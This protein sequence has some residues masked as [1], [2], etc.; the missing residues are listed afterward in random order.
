MDALI[1]VIFGTFMLLAFEMGKRVEKTDKPIVE[2]KVKKEK[3]ER[4]K[5]Q[6]FVDLDEASTIMLENL[7]NYDGTGS[8]QKDVPED[9]KDW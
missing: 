1:L 7:D 3:K 5:G 4:K 9:R 8:N 2:K 6:E